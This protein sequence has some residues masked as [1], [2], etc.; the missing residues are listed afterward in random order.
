MK[1]FIATEAGGP[2]IQGSTAAAPPD[3]APDWLQGWIAPAQE[4][5]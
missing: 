5:R 4:A 3:L 1:A 2:Q